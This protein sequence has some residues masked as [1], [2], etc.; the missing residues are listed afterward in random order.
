MKR[1]WLKLAIVGLLTSAT[2]IS[3]F[4]SNSVVKVSA[5]EDSSSNYNYAKALQLS[6]YFYDAEMCGEQDGRLSYRGNCHMEDAKL[7]LKAKTENNTGTNMSNSFIEANKDVLDPDGDGCV[8]VSGGFHDAGD[9]VNFG[10]PQSYSAST[11]GWSY[12]EFKDAFVKTGEDEHMEAI[13]RHF[14]DYFLR[15]TFR[16]KSGDVV[17]FCYQVGDGAADHTYWGSPELQTTPRPAW[18]ATSETPASD[19]CAGAAAALATSYLN[20]KDSDPDYADKCLDTAK[21][22]YDFAV[23]NRGLGYSGGFYGSSFDEDEL[24]WAA[25]WLNIC[26]GKESYIND[27]TAKDE[28][29]T[30]TGYMKRIISSTSSTWQNI[31]VHSWDTVWGGVFAKLA[32][33][34]NDPLHWYFF[35]WNIE[36]WGN[37]KHEDPSDSTYL[38]LT[39]GGFGVISTW[40]SAR[41]NAAAQLCGLVYNKYKEN[42]DFTKWA[43]SQ[44]DYILGDNPM[45]R[46]YLVG[47]AGNSAVQPH[48]RASHGSTTNS[49]TDPHDSKH[50]LWGALVGGPDYDDK[51]VD[52]RTD[53]VY[54]EVAIDYN[55]GFVGAAAG[56]YLLYGDGQ[57]P[58]ESIPQDKDDMPFTTEAKVDQEN[59]ERTQVTVN[60]T[61]D[62]T[63]PPRLV[64]NLSSRYFFDAS[65]LYEHGQSIKDIKIEKMYDEALVKD[66]KGADIKGPFAW[67]EANHIYYVDIDWT[68]DYFHG[69]REIMFALVAGQ[70]ANW[71]SNWDPTNDYSREGLSDEYQASPRIPVYEGGD[72]KFG[73][74]PKKSEQ[75]DNPS[76]KTAKISIDSPYNQAVLDTTKGDKSIDIK[77]GLEGEFEEVNVYADGKLIGQ[78]SKVTYAPDVSKMVSAKGSK[79]VKITA[80]GTT[81]NGK[82]V[83]AKPVIIKV[84]FAKSQVVDS[85][86]KLTVTGKG[87]KK[88][89]TITRKYEI[90]NT[91]DKDIDLSDIKIRYY[92]TKDAQVEQRFF[93]DSA[94]LTLQEAPWYIDITKSVIGETV[95][96]DGDDCYLEISF[97]D[98]IQGKLSKG[99]TISLDTRLANSS[100]S[101]LDQSNDYSY[102]GG[103]KIVMIYADDIVS[104]IEP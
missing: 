98:D 3:P 69:S 6:L 13:L 82:K 38:A 23:A 91:G 50:C 101:M 76:D 57:E 4:A 79:N 97:A 12:Y 80:Q 18:F 16:D 28:D 81:K 44:M 27:I 40:G 41:Y 63:C 31:W 89:N 74:E 8:D 29:G 104:G 26:T 78:G 48:H 51:H 5:K 86:L 7:P 34:T 96:Y 87:D 55:A 39:P 9:H 90:T 99:A 46:C 37:I 30:Y 70:D 100:W 35:R 32:P 66:Q 85:D 60:I 14:T 102:E 2:I 19:Q 53:Y 22:L 83:E 56:I 20:F 71:D 52:D 93:A 49:M 92:Y 47:Y 42:A 68:G 45:D 21:A 73:N 54:N 43:K 62:T 75:T 15:C 10:L 17:A 88:E 1:K 59:S 65:E 11:L 61:C 58:M 36:Y 25:V 95:A 84:K 64:G 103:D 24:S 77:L 94:S 72:L 33:V 67:D